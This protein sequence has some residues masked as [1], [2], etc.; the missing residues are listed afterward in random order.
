MLEVLQRL[1]DADAASTSSDSDAESN[2]S[3]D[4]G[5]V[6]AELLAK[7]RLQVQSISYGLECGSWVVGCLRQAFTVLE[8]IPATVLGAIHPE[9]GTNAAIVAL[10]KATTV[11]AVQKLPISL[12]TPLRLV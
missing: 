10:R 9:Q 11:A 3:E 7:L 8:S 4:D 1:H 2:G 12:I 5:P 6:P